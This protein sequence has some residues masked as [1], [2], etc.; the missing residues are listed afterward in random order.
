MRCSATSQKIERCGLRTMLQGCCWTKTLLRK[1]RSRKARTDGRSISSRSSTPRC[2]SSHR[3]ATSPCSRTPCRRPLRSSWSICRTSSWCLSLKRAATL[4][5]RPTGCTVWTISSLCFPRPLTPCGAR[6]L[7][8]G[9]GPGPRT[10]RENASSSHHPSKLVPLL[11]LPQ[12]SVWMS[13]PS[14]NSRGLRARAGGRAAATFSSQHYTRIAT[15]KPNGKSCRTAGTPGSYLR[16]SL[17]PSRSHPPPRVPP[18]WLRAGVAR[19]LASPWHS[20]TAFWASTSCRS[21]KRK[22]PRARASWRCSPACR[23]PWT[24]PSRTTSGRGC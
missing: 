14:L 24:S 21:L 10:P 11:R 16:V 9:K 22:V 3:K 7:A 19:T 13:S 17:N 8:V 4:E 2:T 20:L 5:P 6:P 23:A 15:T 12:Y 18:R 1:S